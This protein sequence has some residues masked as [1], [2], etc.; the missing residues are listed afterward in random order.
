MEIKKLKRELLILE[1]KLG[2]LIEERSYCETKL[3]AIHHL[4][5]KNEYEGA[6]WFI[7]PYEYDQRKEGYINTA[8]RIGE[9]KAIIEREERL[10]RFQ[11]DELRQKIL[12][13]ED[14]SA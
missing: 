14:Q 12:V 10:I 2:E 5:V 4:E 11:C 9:E 13:L 7:T 3:K 1:K 6:N 8:R